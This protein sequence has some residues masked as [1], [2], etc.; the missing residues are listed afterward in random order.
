[1]Y[2]P[3]TF[4]TH[5]TKYKLSISDL[6]VVRLSVYACTYVLKLLFG[7]SVFQAFDIY[8][9]IYMWRRQFYQF[10]NNSAR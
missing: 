5:C 4:T 2:I 1:M 9:Y 3:V 6:T 7:T 8:I 10:P